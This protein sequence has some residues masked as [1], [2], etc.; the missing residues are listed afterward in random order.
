[1]KNGTSIQTTTCSKTNVTYENLECLDYDPTDTSHIFVGGRNGLYEY[2]N[3]NF[4]NYYNYENSPI[5]RYNNR[6]KEYEP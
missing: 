1:M 6:S 2:K 5:E 3:G 4:E